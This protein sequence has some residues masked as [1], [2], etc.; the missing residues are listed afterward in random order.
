MQAET[1]NEPCTFQRHLQTAGEQAVLLTI[2]QQS[3]SSQTLQ[4][5][6]AD[7]V[8][9]TTR[10]DFDKQVCKGLQG[11]SPARWVSR[12]LKRICGGQILR[13]LSLTA[14][15]QD[16]V[17]QFHG[18]HAEAAAA[19]FGYMFRSPTLWEDLVKSITLCNCG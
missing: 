1:Y 5:S 18:L 19:S 15:D 7:P 16:I 3:P 2:T 9:N 10:A 4:V 13:M 11:R 17:R 14:R 6:A 8:S 12:G